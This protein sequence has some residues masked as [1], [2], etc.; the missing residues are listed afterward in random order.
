MTAT[1]YQID[2]LPGH[3]LASIWPLMTGY[4]L[5][6]IVADMRENG[7][8]DSEGPITTYQGT[9]L[10][11][12]NRAR[13]CHLAGVEPLVRE[14][15]GRGSMVKFVLSANLH[16]RHLDKA[17]LAVVALELLPFATDEA[18]ARLGKAG[19]AFGRGMNRVGPDGP[20]LSMDDRILD[21]GKATDVVGE[22]VGTSGRSVRRAQRVQ[23]YSPDLLQ[24]VKA[25]EIS[26]VAAEQQ[27]PPRA[28][29]V[30]PAVA[31]AG[32]SAKLKIK[33]AEEAAARKNDRQVKAFL[34][35]LDGWT[36]K[37]RRFAELNTQTEVLSKF[38]PEGAAF[39]ARHVDDLLAEITQL[40]TTLKGRS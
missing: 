17:E 18:K 20:R 8:R 26:L 22:M 37:F 19:K 30:H 12:R 28:Q 15:N 33:A 23:S 7:Y 9:I 32:A 1:K 35:G 2:D 39:A 21:P 5:D 40:S 10:D 36:V 24:E 3:P 11:G 34:K 4:E 14:W 29:K 31:R 38:S 6:R 25:H 16:R 13:A 27:V